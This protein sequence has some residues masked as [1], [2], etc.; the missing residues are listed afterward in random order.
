[1]GKVGSS[2][3]M[4]LDGYIAFDDNHLQRW[5]CRSRA[6]WRPVPPPRAC[7]RGHITRAGTDLLAV[8]DAVGCDRASLLSLYGATASEY[9][10][11]PISART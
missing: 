6:S 8:M 5:G 10:D 9:P 4:S 3:T 11:P 2:A 1:M 7:V